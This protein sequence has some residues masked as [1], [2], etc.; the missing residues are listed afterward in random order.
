MHK[1]LPAYTKRSNENLKISRI[2]GQHYPGY[3]DN[4]VTLLSITTDNKLKLFSPYFC[5][6]FPNLQ[7]IYTQFVNL[8]TFDQDSLAKCGN[9]KALSSNGNR[10][11]AIANICY[12]GTKG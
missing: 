3:N 8:L 12:T 10:L 7:V 1:S 6:K 11:H 2:I 5:R 4:Y 9:L